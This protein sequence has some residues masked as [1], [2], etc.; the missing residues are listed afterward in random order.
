MW[1]IS[2]SI[3]IHIINHHG[4]GWHPISDWWDGHIED[5]DITLSTIKIS[6]KKPTQANRRHQEDLHDF[7]EWQW[8][9]SMHHLL[10]YNSATFSWVG[11]G[12]SAEGSSGCFRWLDEHNI[13]QLVELDWVQL[14]HLW[15]LGI[16][17]MDPCRAQC[18]GIAA[19]GIAS[20]EVVSGE[21]VGDYLFPVCEAA[22]RSSSDCWLA[23]MVVASMVAY[24]SSQKCLRLGIDAYAIPQL[25]L[26]CCFRSPTSSDGQINVLILMARVASL[27]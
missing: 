9:S 21:W 11:Y 25:T 22:S 5:I 7:N 26:S 15:G 6:W 18:R 13:A 4:I 17:L 19:D 23:Q 27:A 24:L 2:S 1:L 3:N 14:D 12:Q 20:A 10:M 8:D 16:A